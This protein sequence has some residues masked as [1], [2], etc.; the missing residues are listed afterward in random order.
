MIMG[1]FLLSHTS[2]LV[3]FRTLDEQALPPKNWATTGAKGRRGITLTPLGPAEKL[4]T[5]VAGALSNVVGKH[6]A[7]KAQEVRVDHA[8]LDDAALVVV[9]FGFPGRFVKY[10]VR[11]AREQGLQ[12]G[13]VRP[14]SL[15]PF[16]S[17]AIAAAAE[18]A[19]SIAVFEINAGQMIE[20]VQLAVL[21][22]VPVVAIG[23]ISHD[24]SGFGVGPILNVEYIL[25][26]IREV[27]P[28]H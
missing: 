1:D 19:G 26:R 17:H 9:A 7:I 3:E 22:K 10:A 13:Y 16:P 2:E 5:N 11:L 28:A 15:W 20:D 27:Y 24:Y 21:G 12:V 25:Q 14:V 8:W 18:H 6:P 4:S 23:G